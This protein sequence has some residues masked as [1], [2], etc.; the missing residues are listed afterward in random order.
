[1]STASQDAGKFE[2][3]LKS[4]DDEILSLTAQLQRLNVEK[5]SEMARVNEKIKLVIEGKDHQIKVIII[6]EIKEEN[7]LNFYSRD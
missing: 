3:E 4:R 1:M 6:I 2:S 5:E 7:H